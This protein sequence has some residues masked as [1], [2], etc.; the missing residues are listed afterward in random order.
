M[1]KQLTAQNQVDPLFI[2]RI[3][4]TSFT[5]QQPDYTG[6]A[7]NAIVECTNIITDP[8]ATVT[9]AFGQKCLLAPAKIL[10]CVKRYMMLNCL[11]SNLPQSASLEL[12]A[13][14][15]TS[16]CLTWIFFG[17]E[18][19]ESIQG[20]DFPGLRLARSESMNQKRKYQQGRNMSESMYPVT[21]VFFIV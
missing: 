12:P 13:I 21:N 2:Y 9:T 6:I 8:L 15:F 17:H 5:G 11:Q 18:V 3:V 4:E 16:I 20:E 1:T 19:P 14:K 10:R 7:Y